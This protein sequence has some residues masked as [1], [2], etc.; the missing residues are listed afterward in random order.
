MKK[1]QQDK[2]SLS[3]FTTTNSLKVKISSPFCHI[4]FCLSLGHIHTSPP[5]KSSMNHDPDQ[6]LL[7]PAPLPTGMI[8]CGCDTKIE[9]MNLLLSSFSEDFCIKTYS[10]KP[11]SKQYSLSSSS[12]PPTKTNH[13]G[14]I[15]YF[16][17]ESITFGYD[18]HHHSALIPMKLLITDNDLRGY[19]IHGYKPTVILKHFSTNWSVDKSIITLFLV[20]QIHAINEVKHF[21]G[22][23]RPGAIESEERCITI[24][25]NTVS[26]ND[27]GIHDVQMNTYGRIFTHEYSNS[28]RGCDSYYKTSEMLKCERKLLLKIQNS[29]QKDPH[30]FPQKYNKNVRPEMFV[31]MN[32]GLISLRY[33]SLLKRG[34]NFEEWSNAS[35]ILDFDINNDNGE[36][37]AF[38]WSSCFFS[39]SST[40]S[41]QTWL[42]QCDVGS[43]K[44]KPT[45]EHVHA[46]NHYLENFIHTEVLMLQEN[47]LSFEKECHLLRFEEKTVFK[48]K[49]TKDDGVYELVS[50]A[51]RTV[52][53][54]T[55]NINIVFKG[56]IRHEEK[57]INVFCNEK[58]FF[59]ICRS[60][61]VYA[62]ECKSA[63]NVNDMICL[64]DY[65]NI[66]VDQYQSE[67]KWYLDNYDETIN[68]EL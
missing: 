28:F 13:D 58:Y 20:F 37:T 54:V 22:N 33:L 38:C 3:S 10:Y 50:S 45:L 12:S 68:I 11:T 30:P 31:E 7:L 29:A 18:Q 64:R 53:N 16:V 60:G 14:G 63:I 41:L 26:S 19:F 57:M 2:S 9:L 36:W 17:I 5:Q 56:R 65:Y 61:S 67:T 6:P 55:R 62:F 52:V 47:L 42:D 48:R 32:P 25:F 34:T 46:T 8:Y 4:F 23:S 21:L 51:P 59:I 35:Q 15:P 24:H 49:S 39:G 66:A 40:I 43:R 1:K 27:F 44:K